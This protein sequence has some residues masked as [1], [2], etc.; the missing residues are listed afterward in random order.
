MN[1][2][3][4]P[5]LTQESS[6]QR[7]RRSER[8]SPMTKPRGRP[9]GLRHVF[10]SG[11]CV[12]F[13]SFVLNLLNDFLKNILRIREDVFI[14]VMEMTCLCTG[15]WVTRSE[16]P[17]RTAG[18]AAGAVR[19]LSGRGPRVRE[20]YGVSLLSFFFAPGSAALKMTG[21][22]NRLHHDVVHVQYL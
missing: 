8:G 17:A 11:K 6:E 9:A 12:L 20:R 3:F 10:A 4:N 21:R 22:E 18:G 5:L 2:L 16:S 1:K 14:S 13:F 7:R 15:F 19:A